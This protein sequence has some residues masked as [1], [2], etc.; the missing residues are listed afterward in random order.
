M[1]TLAPEH[2]TEN[3]TDPRWNILYKVGGWATLIIPLMY[4][5]TGVITMRGYRS[6]PFPEN[7]NEWFTVLQ[8]SPLTGLFYLGFADIII[9]IVSGLMTLALYV[10]LKRAGS[11]LAIIAAPFAFVGIAV[12]LTSNTAFGMLSLSSQYATAITEAQKA[13]LMAAGQSILTTV[14][15]TGG[16]LGLA[17]VWASGL[18]FSVVMLR[19][20]SFGKVTGWFG[21]VAFVFL[22]ASVPFGSYTTV[23]PRGPVMTAIVYVFNFGGALLSLIWYILVGVKL[24]K[25]ARI[26]YKG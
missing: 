3:R 22:I 15:G 4:I 11:T 12:Y 21:I 14:E 25:L 5:I 10:A 17:I 1:P 26:V 6:A 19:S 8:N 7:V 2:I 24:L 13:T 23:E 18:I 20:Q 9:T 16:I